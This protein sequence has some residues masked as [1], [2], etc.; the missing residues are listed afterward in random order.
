MDSKK[1]AAPTLHFS[2]DA[3]YFYTAFLPKIS[4]MTKRTIKIKNKTF[5]IPAAPAAMPPKPN[6]AA[7][8]ATIKK[9]TV[10]RNIG[11][12]FMMNNEKGNP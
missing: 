4:E 11:L 3:R 12:I 8:M 5:A 2:L 6:I 9:I 1:N 10:Q 7:M